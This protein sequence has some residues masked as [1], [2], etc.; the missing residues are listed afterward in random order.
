MPVGVKA[1]DPLDDS[2]SLTDLTRSMHHM[3]PLPAQSASADSSVLQ[4]AAHG[5]LVQLM[6]NIAKATAESGTTAEG[7]ATDGGGDDSV[8]ADI[9]HAA[10]VSLAHPLDFEGEAELGGLPSADVEASQQCL[11]DETSSRHHA[12]G[13]TS[14]G[15]ARGNSAAGD[16]ASEVDGRSG[17]SR[18]DDMPIGSAQDFFRGRG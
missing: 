11:K 8:G 5:P 9:N 18:H 10:G 17:L 6:H 14:A 4:P 12:Q 15:H 1:L 16:Q 13:H 3:Q 2:N 7:S